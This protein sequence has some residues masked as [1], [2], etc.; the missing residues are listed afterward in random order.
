M[1]CNSDIEKGGFEVLTQEYVRSLTRDKDIMC[2]KNDNGRALLVA[3]SHCMAGAA[4][5]AARACLR[6]G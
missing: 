4:V 5:M 1:K 3:G 6:S 2:D